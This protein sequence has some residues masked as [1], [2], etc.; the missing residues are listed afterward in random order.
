[1]GRFA[2]RSHRH[3]PVIRVRLAEPADIPHLP[4]IELAAAQAFR[5][6][7]Q[8]WCAEAD[9]MPAEDYPPLVEDGDVWVAEDDGVLAGFVVTEMEEDFLHI[10][11][12]AVHLD[13][14]R[15][16]AGRALIAAVA[17][18][19]RAAGC[20]SVTLSTFTNVEFNQPYYRALGFELIETP[21]SWLAGILASEVADGFTDRCAMRLAL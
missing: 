16:G 19:A 21:N 5:G 8:A 11:E 4:G 6:T 10:W 17:E 2:G 15:K 13:H 20:T 7:P 1:M 14:Q 3:R 9:V 12:L 18:A